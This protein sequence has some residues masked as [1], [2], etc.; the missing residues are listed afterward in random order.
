M[1]QAY[2]RRLALGRAM[3][4][5]AASF[6]RSRFRDPTLEILEKAPNDI[7]TEVDTAIET[8]LR[9]RIKDA[10]PGDAVFGE[11]LGLDSRGS[12]VETGWIWLIDPI[13][14]TANFATGLAY[15]CV[16]LALISEGQPRAAWICDPEA[17]ELFAATDGKAFDGADCELVVTGRQNL[18]G[19]VVGLGFSERHPSSLNGSVVSEMVSAGIEYRRLGSG[20]LSLAHVAAGRLDGYFEPHMNPWD[21]VGGLYIAACA[22]AKTLDYVGQDGL[23][24]GAPAF[25][26]TAAIAEP[27]L[28]LMP[29]QFEGR[30]L[31]RSAAQQTL[32]PSAGGGGPAT[33]VPVRDPN[34]GAEK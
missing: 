13:D 10:F 11:E 34:Q 17:D 21:A 1:M 12:S 4:L 23:R 5:D 7:V 3:A 6:A 31:G 16:S 8:D 2:D 32:R 28:N 24:R 9:R 14:G 30:L 27:L 29:P 26:A 20:A 18:S 15:Y 22:G 19:A 33:T 25:A